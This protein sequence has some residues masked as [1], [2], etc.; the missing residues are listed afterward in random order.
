[1]LVKNNIEKRDVI[2]SAF[3]MSFALM[4]GSTRMIE[5]FPN[6]TLKGLLLFA[7]TG[8][9]YSFASKQVINERSELVRWIRVTASYVAG[10][11]FVIPTISKILKSERY[12]IGFLA[13]TRLGVVATM[14]N[15]S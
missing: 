2:E 4:A 3:I 15:T 8:S 1:M 10:M 13:G 12:S 5:V 9:F 11:T 6:T 14:I 7:S